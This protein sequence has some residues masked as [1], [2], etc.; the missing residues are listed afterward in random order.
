MIKAICFITLAL[1]STSAAI[2]QIKIPDACVRI[3]ASYGVPVPAS[4]THTT[5][6]GAL[7]SLARADQDNPDVKRCIEALKAELKK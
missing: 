7:K 3:A 2:A 4:L 6:K 1:L 5:I